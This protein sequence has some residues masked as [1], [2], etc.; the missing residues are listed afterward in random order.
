MSENIK[1]SQEINKITRDYKDRIDSKYW[2]EFKNIP[3]YYRGHIDNKCSFYKYI[4]E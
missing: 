4:C 2:C 1:I 3:C